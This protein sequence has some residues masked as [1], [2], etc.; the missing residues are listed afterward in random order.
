MS[1][2]STSSSFQKMDEDAISLKIPTMTPSLSDSQSVALEYPN[3]T[4]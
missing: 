2:L 1:F 3:I 4:K